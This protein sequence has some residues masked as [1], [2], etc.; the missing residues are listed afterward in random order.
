L[1]KYQAEFST[2][3]LPLF[4]EFKKNALVPETYEKQKQK[5]IEHKQILD[6]LLQQ[7]KNCEAEFQ[8]IYQ[9]INNSQ[10]SLPEMK[11]IYDQM[12][13]DKYPNFRPSEKIDKLLE[14]II[15]KFANRLG[16]FRV[17]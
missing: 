10:I 14:E 12:G 3:L 17:N 9:Q 1:K 5:S 6:K 2:K 15:G 16:D 8:S 13:I 4:A 11:K 7:E